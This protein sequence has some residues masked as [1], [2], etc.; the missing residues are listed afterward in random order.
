M[1]STSFSYIAHIIVL[2]SNYLSLRLP[3]EI[4]LSHRNYP[5]PTIYA[6]SASYL[7]RYIHSQSPDHLS[8]SGPT[9][10]CMTSG[11]TLAPRPR[12]ICIDKPL[13]KLAKED[14]G[15]YALF[16][17]GTSLL[18]WNVSWLCRSQGLNLGSDTWED[19]CDVGK[20][21][22]Q[23]LVAPP[24]QSSILARALAGHDIQAKM[25]TSKDSPRTTIQRT[26]SLP[27]LGNYSHGTA[28]SF[29]AASEGTDFM[30]TWR[31]PTP[32]KVADRLKSTLLGDMAS[33]EW[34]LL[35]EK[36][37]DDIPPE[38]PQPVE[39]ANILDSTHDLG[40]SGQGTRTLAS[41]LD[42]SDAPIADTARSKG[43]NGWTKLRNRQRFQI[44]TT[45]NTGCS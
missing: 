31:L 37:W 38:L 1:I 33:A 21:L 28:H 30:R 18:A 32:T 27:L 10:S 16:V 22:W 7:P 29:L 14:P 4:T 9:T 23:L 26:K 12:P 41:K 3:A 20:N 13:A 35:E 34:E 45:G 40:A 6:P 24:A 42:G 25:K 43:T 11:H 15:T 8:T 17:E 36:E 5:A 2:I 19:V 44:T 39:S